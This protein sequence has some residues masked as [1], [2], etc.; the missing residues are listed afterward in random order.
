MKNDDIVRMIH[1]IFFGLPSGQSLHN[2]RQSTS[3]MG[4]STMNGPC[5]VAMLY[6]HRVTKVPVVLLEDDQIW[7]VHQPTW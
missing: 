4:K 2:Y 7:V 1:G 3:L 6:Y 5:S